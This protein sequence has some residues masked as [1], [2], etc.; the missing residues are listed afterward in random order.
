METKTA[1]MQPQ[2]K[3]HLEPLE[4][5]RGK[6]GFSPGASRGRVTPQTWISDFWPLAL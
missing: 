3:E 5:G 4:A 6:D 1:V 2:V